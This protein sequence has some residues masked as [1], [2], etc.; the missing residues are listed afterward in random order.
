MWLFSACVRFNPNTPLITDVIFM[1]KGEFMQLIARHTYPTNLSLAEPGSILDW[2]M[3]LRLRGVLLLEDFSVRWIGLHKKK[4]VAHRHQDRR[5][6]VNN[7][8]SSIIH[9]LNFD[10]EKVRPNQS[11]FPTRIH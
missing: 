9:Y 11:R 3:R 2:F 5:R 6:D 1:I 7:E 8:K 10:W 4:D